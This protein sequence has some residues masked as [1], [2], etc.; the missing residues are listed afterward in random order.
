MRCNAYHQF[1]K[2]LAN[3]VKT[4]IIQSLK[5]KDKCVNELV[6]DLGIEQSKLSHA[7]AN[8]RAC[9]LVKSKQ[10]GKQRV[11]SLNKNT[12]LPILKIIDKHSEVYCPGCKLK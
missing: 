8:L 3:P 9:H 4:Q 2:N 11:Y 1:F 12:I 5:R 6:N 10:V 7:L